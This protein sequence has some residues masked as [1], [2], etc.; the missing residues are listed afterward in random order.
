VWGANSNQESCGRVMGWQ[1]PVVSQSLR[2][3]SFIFITACFRSLRDLV[4]V[5]RDG[6]TVVCVMLWMNHYQFISFYRLR[7][8]D[9]R[10]S[11]CS[12]SPRP[13]S[14]WKY[15]RFKCHD[16]EKHFLLEFFKTPF[17][18][19]VRSRWDYNRR[20]INERKRFSRIFFLLCGYFFLRFHKG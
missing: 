14:L 1:G 15:F 9:Q 10:R 8:L 6:S 19:C 3:S 20:I 18:I 16:T 7:A 4:A 17:F 12:G 13:N 5:V 2:D 11:F